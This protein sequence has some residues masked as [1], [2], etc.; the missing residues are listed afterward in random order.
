MTLALQLSLLALMGVVGGF[1]GHRLGESIRGTIGDRM[2]LT[3]ILQGVPLLPGA[4]LGAI[5]L[6]QYST[7]VLSHD[8][9]GSSALVSVSFGGTLLASYLGTRFALQSRSR[10]R[11]KR[12]ELAFPF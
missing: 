10:A 9:A 7:Y 5:F 1:L 2:F 8:P 4:L 3:Y 12:R 6:T 11:A